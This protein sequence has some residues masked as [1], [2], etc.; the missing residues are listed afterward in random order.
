MRYFRLSAG[1]LLP[2]CLAALLLVSS[3]FAAPPKT[4]E[5][6]KAV[7]VGDRLVDVALALGVIPEGASARSM[8]PAAKCLKYGVQLLGCPRCVTV[9]KPETVKRFMRQ[10][11]ITRLMVEKSPQ[12]CLYMKKV[13][14]MN[15]VGVVKDVPGLTVEYVDFSQGVAKAVLEAGKLLGREEKAQKIAA[16]YEQKMGRIASTA[17][18]AKGKRVL[19]LKGT[20]FPKTGKAFVQAEAPDG[21]SD[22]FLLAPLG[23]VN[24]VGDMVAP[25]AKATKGYVSVGR[26]GGLAKAAPDV[27]VMTGDAYPVQAALKKALD[28]DPSLAEVPALKNAAVFSLPLY[29]DSGVL[30]YPNIFKQWREALA[31][32]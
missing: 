31:G 21:Y 5:R 25:D 2:A 16:S 22:R 6:I 13:N 26:L 12:F 32:G 7:M 14:P 10:R 15:V 19:I 4:P 23:C 24:A 17:P 27:I 29:L 1:A 8:W 30:E 18:V 11:G 3:V 9:K 28:R 20:Y